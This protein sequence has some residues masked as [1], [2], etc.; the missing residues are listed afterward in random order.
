MQGTIT[1]FSRSKKFFYVSVRTVTA[2]QTGTAVTVQKFFS[3]FN[4][5]V[6][7]HCPEDEVQEGCLVE[8]EVDP[9]PRLPG[10]DPVAT[11]VHVYPKPSL[12]AM[13]AAATALSGNVHAEKETVTAGGVS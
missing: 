7:F 2:T 11:H 9:A 1:Y 12:A 5:I 3:H 6:F 4:R 13:T 10:K 8:F